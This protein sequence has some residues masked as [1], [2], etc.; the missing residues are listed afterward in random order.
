MKRLLIW[1]LFCGVASAQNPIPWRQ[2]ADNIPISKFNGGA[3]ATS[4]TFW[5]GDGTWATPAASSGGWTDDGT[6]VRL[7][8][9]TDTVGIG[10]AAPNN[11]LELQSATVNAALRVNGIATG[12]A[13]FYNSQSGA[14]F[15]RATFTV[16]AYYNGAA[17]SYVD[18][19]LPSWAIQLRTSEDD[20]VVGRG[21]PGTFPGGVAGTFLTIKNTGDVGIGTTLPADW[22]GVTA[23]GGKNLQ[24]KVT[25]GTARAIVNAAAVGNPELHLVRGASSADNRNWRFYSDGNQLTLDQPSDSY[26]AT[27]MMMRWLVHASNAA[28]IEIHGSATSTTLDNQI[29]S[30]DS[31]SQLNPL[32]LNILTQ[33]NPAGTAALPAYSFSGDTNSGIYSAGADNLG[34]SVAGAVQVEVKPFSSN[35]A[36]II[37]R[38]NA[39]STTLA[40]TLYSYDT[41]TQPNP[42]NLVATNF[43]MATAAS[44]IE[45]LGNG[46]PAAGAA[47]A[48]RLFVDAGGGG[49]KHRLMVQFGS[50]VAILLATEP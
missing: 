50:G 24:V 4:S 42:M 2:I 30:M 15:D 13:F 23:V 20:F 17:W 39:S 32:K 19:L 49:G 7:T 36:Q 40:N 12:A 27:E 34:I 31:G 37:F 1:L 21:A 26:A 11:T 46:A 8:T 38:G 10:T 18:S 25:S 28:Q 47:A 41:G 9:A 6:V 16:N 22:S 5:R 43:S 3:G 33:R 35:A 44:F 48:A 29:S 14:G 45:L